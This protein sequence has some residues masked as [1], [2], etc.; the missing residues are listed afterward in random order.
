MPLSRALPALC[1]LLAVAAPL[2]AGD[3]TVAQLAEEA[4]PSTAVLLYTGRE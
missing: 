4:R 2:A 3:K 1:L